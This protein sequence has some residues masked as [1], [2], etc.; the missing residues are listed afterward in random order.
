MNR[1]DDIRLM[2]RLMDNI[3]DNVYVMDHKG[4][5]TFINDAGA[6]WLGFNSPEEVIGKTDLDIFSN[7]HGSAAFDDEQRIMKTGKPILG[8]EEK[9]TWADGHETWV[10][11][12]KMPLHNDDGDIVGTFG[13]S[14]DI[15]EHKQAEIRAST[16]A[17]ENRRFREEMEAELQ[18][19]GELQKTFFPKS[20]PVFPDGVDAADSLVRFCHYHHAGG[21]VG[22]DFCSIRKLSK[23]EVGIFLCDVMGHGVRAALGTAIVRAVVEEISHKEKDPGHFLAH[24][25][26]VLL[27]IMRQEDEFLYATACYMVVDVSTG[28]VRMANAGHPTPI[29]LDAANQCAEWFEQGESIAGPALAICEDV[30]YATVERLLHPRDAVVLFTDGIYEVAGAGQEEFGEKRLLAA[31][32]RHEELTLRELFPAMLNEARRFAAEGA[33]DDDVCLVGFRLVDLLPAQQK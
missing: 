1:L 19:A 27:P 18:M 14:R 7:E 32:Q 33:F 20:Y 21:M 16:Y 26:Q 2:K 17:E 10:S 15:T 3:Q 8:I 9:E 6:K 23:T 30:G 31:A 4:R 24:M 13:I 11:T 22:G 25:N 28:L 29:L 12:S 5:I